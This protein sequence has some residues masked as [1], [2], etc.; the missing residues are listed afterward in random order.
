MS[1]RKYIATRH[2]WNLDIAARLGGPARSARLHD[3]LQHGPRLL[4]RHHADCRQHR[5]QP[6]LEEHAPEEGAKGGGNSTD[7]GGE[8]DTERDDPCADD[9]GNEGE[10]QA[11]LAQA[12]AR[13]TGSPEELAAVRV[14]QH[15]RGAGGSSVI[16]GTTG[17]EG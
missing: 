4:T 15:R 7:Q 6:C 3:R 12:R 2:A 10:A 13:M 9:E 14:D 17:A 1:L 8:E 16:R 11:L 5:L